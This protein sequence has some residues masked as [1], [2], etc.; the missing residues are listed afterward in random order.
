ML[1]LVVPRREKHLRW[2]VMVESLLWPLVTV[3]QFR[4]ELRV[5]LLGRGVAALLTDCR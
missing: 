3:R 4:C 2:D 5:A 1:R